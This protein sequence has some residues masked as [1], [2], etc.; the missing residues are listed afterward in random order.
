MPGHVYPWWGGALLA[1][2]L[3]RLFLCP[4]SLLRPY[5]SEGMTVVDFGC[6]MGFFSLPLAESVGASGKVHCIDLQERMLRGLE[7]RAAREGLSERIE[8]RLCGPESIGAEELAGLADFVLVVHVLHELPD[9]DRFLAELAALLKPGGRA[10]VLE[11][12][13]RV[14]EADLEAIVAGASEA[15]LGCSLPKAGTSELSLLFEKAPFP[16]AEA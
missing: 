15:G 8:T 9:R 3:H 16:S 7:R 5:V 10:L 6:G 2:P 12:R 13:R 11:P 1:S 14:S 4:E